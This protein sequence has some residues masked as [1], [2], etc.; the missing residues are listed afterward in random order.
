MKQNQFFTNAWRNPF[1]RI[2]WTFFMPKNG[3]S[4]PEV[5]NLTWHGIRVHTLWCDRHRIGLR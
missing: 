3:W 2:A 4:D 5:M 1:Q